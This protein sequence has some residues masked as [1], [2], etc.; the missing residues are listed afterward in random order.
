M[1]GMCLKGSD[2][3]MVEFL[4]VIFLQTGPSSAFL[5]LTLPFVCFSLS[6][7]LS[8]LKPC[9]FMRE[10]VEAEFMRVTSTKCL[11]TLQPKWLTIVRL[12]QKPKAFKCHHP[13]TDGIPFRSCTASKRMAPRRRPQQRKSGWGRGWVHQKSG[14]TLSV[15]QP[16]QVKD[17]LYIYICYMHCYVHVH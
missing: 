2:L 6:L 12:P 10:N 5:F 13:E 7:S 17:H 15:K 11:L 14:T 16:S 3:D 1:E 4:T 8:L 9:R